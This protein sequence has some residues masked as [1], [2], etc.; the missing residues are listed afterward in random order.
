MLESL[1]DS[2][3]NWSKVLKSTYWKW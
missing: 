1:L 2:Y 3:F